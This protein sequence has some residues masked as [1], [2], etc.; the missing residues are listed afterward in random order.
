MCELF[1]SY[2]TCSYILTIFV[3]H[4]EMNNYKVMQIY[5]MANAKNKTPDAAEHGQKSNIILFVHCK[6]TDAFAGLIP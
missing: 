4:S 6:Y 3:E 5:E 2:A 1:V